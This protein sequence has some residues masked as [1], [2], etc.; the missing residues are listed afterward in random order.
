MEGSTTFSDGDFAPFWITANHHG[1]SSIEKNSAYLRTGI[2]RNIETDSLRQW[3]IG[4]GADF[5][6]GKNFTSNFFIQQL[7]AEAEYKGWRFT[8]GSKER[9]MELKNDKLSTGELLQSINAHPI[10]QFR[11]DRPYFWSIPGTKGWLSV[12]GHFAYGWFTD[13][14]FNESFTEPARQEAIAMKKRLPHTYR[15]ELY[16]SKAGFIRV[17]NEKIFP[18]SFTAAF[19]MCSQFGGEAWNV[20]KRLDDNSDFDPSYIKQGKGLTNFWHAFI[21]GGSDESD[22]DY[23]NNEG[24]ILGNYMFSLD[25]HGKGWALRTYTDHFFEDSSGLFWD[26]GWKDW[27]WGFEATLPKNPFVTTILYEYL[28][29]KDQSSGIYHDDTDALPIHNCGIDDYYNH[30]LYGWQNWGQGVGNP[31]LL[32]P[33]Y[34]KNRNLFF[35]H[36]RIQSH[37]LGISGDPTNEIHYRLLWTFVKS[38][39]VYRIP[40]TNPQSSHY[41]LIEACYHPHFL[42]GWSLTVACGINHGSLIGKSTGGQI[43]IRKSFSKP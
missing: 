11:I 23:K 5:V 30:N 8:F 3:R 40:L 7:Y 28:T 13:G 41:Y 16:H 33:I 35:Y 42:K 37:H 14:N 10:P 9:E 34:N 36:N 12:K 29:T 4:Y 20:S 24:N 19:Q 32:S 21:P 43:T 27:L 1:V 26:F 31:L 2:I 25:Y 22:G 6:L 15:G 17:G 18:I 39:G 38:W